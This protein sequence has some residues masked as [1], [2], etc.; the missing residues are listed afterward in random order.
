MVTG[1]ATS[2][3][4][5]TQGLFWWHI[6]NML[7]KWQHTIKKNVYLCKVKFRGLEKNQINSYG[8][9]EKVVINFFILKPIK[10]ILHLSEVRT[11]L[12]RSLST[13]SFRQKWE[14]DTTKRQFISKLDLQPSAHYVIQLLIWLILDMIMIVV[15]SH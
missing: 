4:Q 15:T 14:W 3:P 2:G 9:S 12:T 13:A 8:E 11:H 10:L 5:S 6:P 1:K 7:G